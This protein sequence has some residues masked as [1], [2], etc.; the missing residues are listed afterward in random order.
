MNAATEVRTAKDQRTLDPARPPRIAATTPDT[1]LAVLVV[2]VLAHDNG[3]V[4]DDADR[5]NEREE[6]NGV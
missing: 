4:D 6:R 1:S 5:Q 2:D 3:I